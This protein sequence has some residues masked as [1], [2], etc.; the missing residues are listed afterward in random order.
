MPGRTIKMLAVAVPA[1][2]AL[3]GCGGG[4]VRTGSAAIVGD[5]RITISTLG[6]AVEDWEREFRADPRANQLRSMNP[7]PADTD[8]QNALF[9]LVQIRL[10]DEAARRAGLRVSDGQVDMALNSLN[11]DPRRGPASSFARARGLPARYARDLARQA[12]IVGE[13]LRR[14]GDDGTGF[15]TLVSQTAQSLGVRINPRYGTFDP[16][17]LVFGPVRTTLSSPGSGVG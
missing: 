8:V 10:T 9:G 15:R 13:V 12:V 3:A 7:P 11:R 5:H 6:Q 4:P 2:V 16:D 1:A 17:R 14:N